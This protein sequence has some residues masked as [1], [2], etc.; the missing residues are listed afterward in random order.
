MRE[1]EGEASRQYPK[2]K[3]DPV[4]TPKDIGATRE[5]VDPNKEYDEGYPPEKIRGEDLLKRRDRESQ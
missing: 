3:K 2:T 5:E 1:D 4:E